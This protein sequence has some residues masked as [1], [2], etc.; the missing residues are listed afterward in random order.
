MSVKGRGSIYHPSHP[1]VPESPVLIRI[2]KHLNE[3]VDYLVEPFHYGFTIPED[4]PMTALVWSPEFLSCSLTVEAT[5]EFMWKPYQVT[6]TPDQETDVI[7]EPW[8][9][10]FRNATVPDWYFVDMERK[11]V[12]FRG[13]WVS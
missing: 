4:H 12:Q 5:E 9:D 8:I 10:G 2:W 7:C 1:G 11:G 6:R 13:R 3:P